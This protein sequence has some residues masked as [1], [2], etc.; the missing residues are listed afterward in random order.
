M[1]RILVVD[2]ERDTLEV[3]QWVLT[4]SGWDVK[5]ARCA[6]EALECAKTFA[7]SVVATDYHLAGE[8]TGL[9]LI[10]ELRSSQPSLHA[11]LMT[12]MRADDLGE[13]TSA[14]DDLE[15][16]RKPFRCEDLERLIAPLRMGSGLIKIV[17][18]GEASAG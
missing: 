7:P 10:R 8:L 14:F 16:L 1:E 15:I 9:D 17:Q 5:V 18:L 11:I 6:E 2:D 12:G 13:D 4:D 3:L